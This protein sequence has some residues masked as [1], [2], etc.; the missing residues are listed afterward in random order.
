MY[1]LNSPDLAVA[2]QRN[3]KTL[4]FQAYGA[5]FAAKVC[6]LSPKATKIVTPNIHGDEGSTGFGAAF[7]NVVHS[8]LALGPSLNQLIRTANLGIAASVDKLDSEK[9]IRI[10]LMQWLRHAITLITATDAAYGPSKF[11]DTP[12][13]AILKLNMLTL[14]RYCQSKMM[15]LRTA[16]IS[17]QT[18]YPSKYLPYTQP[19]SRLP[20]EG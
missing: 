12:V 9:P 11:D 19:N 13:I 14:S 8:K 1:I 7:L 10:D 3:S 15:G 16:N 2:L 20:Q 4:S 5:K 18:Q 6:G 17:R